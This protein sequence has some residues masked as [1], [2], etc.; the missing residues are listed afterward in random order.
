MTP[1]LSDI[2]SHV[3]RQVEQLRFDKD[4]DKMTG[5]LNKT[6]WLERIESKISNKKPFGI[7]FADMDNL[8]QINDRLGHVKA[9]EIIK[10]RAVRLSKLFKRHGDH[11]EHQAG[12][13]GGDEF[14]VMFDLGNLG[15]T[16]RPDTPEEEFNRTIEWAK[17]QLGLPIVLK[18]T[19]ISDFGM[20]VGGALWTPDSELS[21][22]QL[23]EL[24]DRDMYNAK[25]TRKSR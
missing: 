22:G 12:R 10:A 17:Y 23:L 25:A 16:N 24:A 6:A 11:L 13:F 21:S 20:S 4:H 2:L 8:K 14:G 5:L 19:E 7:I 3:S 15:G 9:D 18:D 1:D